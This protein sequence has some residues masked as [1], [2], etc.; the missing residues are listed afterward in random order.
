MRS[1]VVGLLLVSC[2]GVAHASNFAI[3]GP[4]NESCGSYVSSPDGSLT[5][6]LDMEWAMGFLTA[7]GEWQ[8]S[9]HGPII[10]TDTNAME[11]WLDNYC[12]AHPL[13]EFHTAVEALT[14]A[15]LA[16]GMQRR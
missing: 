10:K 6:G 4:G 1:I 2:I 9:A 12:R 8:A 16:R 13:Q 11:V 7:M 14:N 3:Y 5:K 15:L